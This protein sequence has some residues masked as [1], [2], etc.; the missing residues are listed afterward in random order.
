MCLLIV[1][2]EIVPQWPLVIAAN[3]DE[4]YDR[5]SEPPRLINDQPGVFGGRDK[6]AGGTW[7]AVNQHGMIGAIANRPLGDGPRKSTRSRGLL[8]LDAAHERS[9]IAVADMIGSALE[10]DD[11]DGFTL[12]CATASGANAFYY[13][14]SLREKSLGRGVFV[15]TTG[16]A[17]DRSEVKTGHALELIG[18]AQPETLNEWIALLEEVCRDHAGG[19]P[20]LETLCMHGSEG[21]TRSSAILAFHET[22]PQCN[23]F[24]YCPGKPC[25]TPYE[26]LQWPRNFFTGTPLTSAERQK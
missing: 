4:R 1:I 13:D 7:L 22:D 10:A 21:G 2:R 24:R 6:V 25:E 19:P 20:G 18:S 5:P 3:R 12:V 26:T 11:Y 17:N 23:L 14:G 9:P 16:D 15:V 8:C